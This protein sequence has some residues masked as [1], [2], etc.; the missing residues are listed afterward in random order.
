MD[1]NVFFQKLDGLLSNKRMDEAEQLLIAGQR[2]TGRR[3]NS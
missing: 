3:K 2:Q 1:Y